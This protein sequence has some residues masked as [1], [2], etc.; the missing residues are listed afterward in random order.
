MQTQTHSPQRGH[1]F[2]NL[3]PDIDRT[4][5]LTDESLPLVSISDIDSLDHE[6]ELSH[7]RELSHD[8]EPSL[9]SMMPDAVSPPTDG[10]VESAAADSPSAIEAPSEESSTGA[11]TALR[12]EV[13]ALSDIGCVRT[14]N[15]DSFG[16]SESDGVYLVCDGMGGMASG[17]VA[18]ASAVATILET[19][20]AS[21]ASGIPISTRL[22]QAIVAANTTVWQQGQVPEHKGMGTTVVAAALDGDKLIIG[23]VGDSRA[24][25]VE[26]GQCMQLT[27]D[28]SYLN[29]LIRN[30]TLT[31]E[32]AHNADL[33]GMESVITRAI[34]AHADVQPDFF[35]IDLHPSTVLLLATDGLTRYLL[36]DE[37]A[38]VLINSPFE[39]TCSNLIQ[40]AKERGGRDN[41]TCLLLRVM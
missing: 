23:N 35:S 31:A 28:H 33:N 36:Q 1:L 24:Y 41:I 10:L 7:D 5:D 20:T 8:Q 3:Y 32:N 15:E 30:G 14:N 19:F 27:V 2:S 29:E 26:S 21:A 37:I 16:F 13:S 11:A 25:M 17:E 18:S 40:L 9:A 4:M 38:L 39:A 6:L 34:G 22:L 12:L